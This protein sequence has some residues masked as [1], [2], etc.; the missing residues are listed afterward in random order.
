MKEI[1][2]SIDIN[3][4]IVNI[5]CEV[6]Y[7]SEGSKALITFDNLGNGI[8]TAVK[9]NA[10]GYN[11]FGDVVS[12]NGKEKFF[13]IIQ[14]INIEKNSIAKDLKA[15]L[16]NSDIRRLELEEYQICY[17]DGSIVTYA[18]K[19][20]KEF[21]TEEYDSYGED[22]EKI[23]A[24][25]DKLGDKI[26]Y[27]PKDSDYGWLC[28][29]GRFNQI[30]ELACSNCE[31]SKSDIFLLT[32]EV[33]VKSIVEQYNKNE[34]ERLK[35]AKQEAIVKEKEVKKRNIKIGISAVIAVLFIVFIINAAVISDRS[36]FSSADE[37][38][39]AM[40]GTYTYYNDSGKAYKQ[41]IISGDKVTYKYNL[42]GNINEIESDI[43]EWN[44]RFGT[45]TTFETLVVT[46]NGNIEDD[47][48]IFT[49]GGTMS[50]YG[51]SN[52]DFFSSYESGFTVLK[53]T[54]VEV[55][56]N[57]SYVICTG[58]V[59]NTGNKTYKFVEVKGA[60]KDSAG[61]VI[62][63]DWGY[64]AGSEGLAPG[65]SSTFRLSVDKNSKILSCS[66]SL[67]DFD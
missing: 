46:N 48:C 64:A 28:A 4:H 10:K 59:K 49:K 26:K 62:D 55:T 37:M 32:D 60:F 40:Q 38:K 56:S 16:P 52:S 25:K 2:R 12:I 24:I 7:N 35:C 47:G 31:N 34:E 58:S 41:I 19:D 9:F 43:K 45:F 42:R 20:S 36:T 54:N 1:K 22:K 21:N 3:A 17:A 6:V 53:I 50:V 23:N 27:K 67:L 39:S 65:E 61:N 33:A 30:N 57:S 63:T 18:R 5:N 51:N 15:K 66:V 11:S 13:L 29:C 8:I 14:D 44:Y